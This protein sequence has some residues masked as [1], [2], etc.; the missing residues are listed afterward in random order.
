MGLGHLLEAVRRWQGHGLR[1]GLRVLTVALRVVVVR[2][3][4]VVVEGTLA[5]M[6]L[7][8]ILVGAW[9]ILSGRVLRL[10][11]WMERGRRRHI[12]L[13]LLRLLSGGRCERIRL[14]LLCTCHEVPRL[15]IVTITHT[16]L[17]LV[18]LV[19]ATHAWDT[20]LVLWLLLIGLEL[21]KEHAERSNQGQQILIASL[22][23][24]R[25]AVPLISFLI[26]LLFEVL[27]TSLTRFTVVG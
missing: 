9:S 3:V 23:G 1:H 25:G 26:P 15:A 5:I 16:V 4:V 27:L 2:V 11:S 19:E 7:L 22:A 6:L 14:H 8:P 10:L 18:V 24:L 21:I 13:H 12:G 20:R 17:V